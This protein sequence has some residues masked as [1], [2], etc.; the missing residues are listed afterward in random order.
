MLRTNVAH[1]GMRSPSGSVSAASDGGD[2]KYGAKSIGKVTK[3][4]DKYAFNFFRWLATRSGIEKLAVMLFIIMLVR[5]PPPPARRAR[6]RA[7][8]R[9]PG[10]ARPGAG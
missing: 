10:R 3:A 8:G 2:D 1:Q 5:L 7:R 6:A 4:A 9:R